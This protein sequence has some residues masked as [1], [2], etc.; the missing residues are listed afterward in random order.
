MQVYALDAP[1]EQ[2]GEP[3]PLARAQPLQLS[4]FPHQCSIRVSYWEQVGGDGAGAALRCFRNGR[5]SAVRLVNASTPTNHS[6]ACIPAAPA[7]HCISVLGPA[8]L[9]FP[10]QV[11]L[12]AAGVARIGDDGGGVLGRGGIDRVLQVAPGHEPLLTAGAKSLQPTRPDMSLAFELPG[13]EV[14]LVDHQTRELLLLSA[15]SIKANVTM[16]SNPASGVAA[17]GRVRE[18]IRLFCCLCPGLCTMLLLTPPVAVILLPWACCAA[19]K[20]VRLSM[21]RLQ[22][23]DMLPGTPFPVVL[24]PALQQQAGAGGTQPVLAVTL[25]SVLGGA[26]G[27]NYMPLV[28][29]RQAWPA[30]CSC[31]AWHVAGCCL[32]NHTSL[33]G[34]DCVANHFCSTVAAT[35]CPA[36][37]GR[38]PSSWPS[39]SSWCGPPTSWCSACR[40]PWQLPQRQALARLWRRQMCLCASACLQWTA[41][42]RRSAS[43]GIPS[44]DPGAHCQLAPAGAGYYGGALCHCTSLALTLSKCWWPLLLLTNLSC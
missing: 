21:Q 31:L 36:A 14:S 41:C 42:T 34:V 12:G 20:S 1:D 11:T 2:E 9:L 32:G 30:A 43:R 15:S 27:R 8:C 33:S 29:V 16:G 37:G 17:G 38:S 39:A 26:R 24:A 4:V 7:A 22:L 44:P 13:L 6:A 40:P 28:A 5:A 3:T 10:P 18:P 19:Y 35:H 23:D 25:T